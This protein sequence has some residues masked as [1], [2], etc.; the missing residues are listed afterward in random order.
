MSRIEVLTDSYVVF[1]LAISLLI[2]TLV[3]GMEWVAPTSAEHWHVG[4]MFL[5]IALVTWVWNRGEKDPHRRAIKE[6]SLLVFVVNGIWAIVLDVIA[7][8]FGI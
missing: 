2:N 3:F 4:L 6:Y 1:I 5:G 7:W 8:V